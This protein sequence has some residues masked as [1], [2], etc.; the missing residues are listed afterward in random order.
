MGRLYKYPDSRASFESVNDE[1]DL[2]GYP[3]GIN[4]PEE[5]SQMMNIHL[6]IGLINQYFK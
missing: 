5:L 6:I 4:I 2:N 3:S 1:Y